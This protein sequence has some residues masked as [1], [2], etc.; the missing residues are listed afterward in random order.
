M[1]RSLIFVYLVLLVSGCVGDPESNKQ[2]NEVPISVLGAYNQNRLFIANAGNVNYNVSKLFT[3][4]GCSVYR[5]E[6]GW[7]RYKYFTNCSGTT[8]WTEYCGKSCTTQESVTGG[9]Q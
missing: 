5:F 8:S 7:A 6:D 2:V 3:Y 9:K 1:K 4:E